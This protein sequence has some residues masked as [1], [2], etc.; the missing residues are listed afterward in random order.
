VGAGRLGGDGR[1]PAGLVPEDRAVV[2]DELMM[3]NVR[4]LPETIVR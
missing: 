2:A 4:L 1:L 3:P